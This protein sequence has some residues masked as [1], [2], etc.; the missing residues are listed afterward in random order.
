MSGAVEK[1]PSW[2]TWSF[3]IGSVSAVFAAVVLVLALQSRREIRQQILDRDAHVL[4]AVA[5]MLQITDEAAPL[6]ELSI[7]LQ[8][9]KLR[10]VLAVRLFD[11]HGDF[12]LS[13]PYN[14]PEDV[15]S[16]QERAKLI[17]GEPI[18]EF[19]PHSDLQ[20][21]FEEPPSE[22]VTEQVPLEEIVIPLH[23][24]TTG[25]IIA[26]I[27][28]IIDGSQVHDEFAQLDRT[29]LIQAGTAFGIGVTA[30]ITVAALA[31]IRLTRSHRAL[32]AQTRR[33]IK[34][35]QDLSLTAR[36]SAVGAVT[37]HL[38]HGIR[39]PLTGLDLFLQTRDAELTRGPSPE[40]WKQL[41]DA[42]N[43][44]RT[45]VDDVV[46]VLREQDATTSFQLTLEELEAVL[47]E[48]LRPKATAAGLHLEQKRSGEAL[49]PGHAANILLL[50]LVNLIDNAVALTPAGKRIWVHIMR[51]P[52]E[53]AFEIGD[54]GP[55]IPEEIRPHL[56]T[57]GRSGRSGGSGLGLAISQR[58]A[59]N[60][61]AD[62]ALVRSDE[63]GT[64]FHL[65]YPLELD[66]GSAG[67][68]N[69]ADAP[70]EFHEFR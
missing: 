69:N 45:L 24:Q 48:K 65:H 61:E 6:D 13:F 21:F 60:L 30:I 68:S 18:A 11:L 4:A 46:E 28:Y 52:T 62:L 29:L 58:L 32:M 9:S 55:G 50:I 5:R 17:R 63:T 37:S 25:Q 47:A 33:L 20:T 23:D 41:A 34:A 56:F 70:R 7:A 35:N 8:T 2:K 67:T 54:E 44:I 31:F 38:I 10:G 12:L 16:A 51:R 64:V 49:L 3:A 22:Q 53:I 59:K 14:V 57:A 1:A 42:T 36:T 39:N 26:M 15:L 19:D 27:Q 43:K 40:S 66:D